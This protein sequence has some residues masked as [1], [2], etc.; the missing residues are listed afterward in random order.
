MI[1]PVVR[2]CDSL[3]AA[4]S[5]GWMNNDSVSVRNVIDAASVCYIV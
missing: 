2:M 4:K 1:G 3:S 5:G